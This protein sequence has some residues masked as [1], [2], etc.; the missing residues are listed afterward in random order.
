M[1]SLAGFF[2]FFFKRYTVC[3][4]LSTVGL[5][6]TSIYVMSTEIV[7]LY[8]PCGVFPTSSFQRV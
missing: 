2:L 4:G 5:V 6:I 3:Y 1:E 7:K 8:T